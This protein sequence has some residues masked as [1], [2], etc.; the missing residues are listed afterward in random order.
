MDPAERVALG[1]VDAERKRRQRVPGAEII[2]LDGLVLALSNVTDPALNSIVVAH[3]PVSASASLAEARDILQRRG[4]PLGIDLQVG[5]HRS[6]DDAVREMGLSCLF[7]RPGMT[8]SVSALADVSVPRG[9]MIRR[10]EVEADVRAF[11]QVGV[12][13]FGDDPDVAGAFYAAGALGVPD[14][15]AFVAW[16]G[17][18]PVGMAAGYLN[19]AAVG[20]MGVGV[21]ASA[22]RR[23]IGAA[24][25]VAAAK[26]FDA[27]DLVWLHPS[28]MAEPLY[29]SLGF[30]RVSE[31]EVWVE[32]EG[33]P[34]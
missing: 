20:I 32:P 29:A 25:T 33:G 9:V 17:D 1:V 2:E 12:D 28:E 18:R 11:V 8:A 5:R 31:W 16:I 26:A 27:A 10:V 19:E 6:V 15:V 24:V 14:A 23:G 30:R 34:S 4:H 22:R 21:V 13:A 3:E 7:R